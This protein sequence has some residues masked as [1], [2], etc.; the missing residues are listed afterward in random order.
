MFFKYTDRTMLNKRFQSAP[1][2]AT[3]LG[4]RVDLIDY[5]QV[6]TR[7]KRAIRR[8]EKITI[9][10]TNVYTIMRARE[11]RELLLDL[12]RF[13]LSVPDGMPLVWLS[14]C[15]DTPIHDRVYGPDLFGLFCQESR[16]GEFRH[17]FYGSTD[18]VLEGLRRNLLK[19]YPGI[20]IA[21]MISPPFRPLTSTEEERYITEINASG[22]DVLWIGIGS[23]KQ[24]KWMA[25]M[26]PRLEV[27]VLAA[28]GAAFDYYAGTKKQ[29][30]KVWQKNGLEWLYRLLQEP[31]RLATRYLVYNPLFILRI[32]QQAMGKKFD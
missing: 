8:R 28:V 10:F 23:P 19:R 7:M 17:F 6:I 30:P 11:D 29:A 25:R 3:I 21:G 13:T 12:S 4:A 16:N 2:S 31:R 14:R 9:G 22:A 1:G 15:T 24:E 27:P 18:T 32:V 20:E 26:R 5:E